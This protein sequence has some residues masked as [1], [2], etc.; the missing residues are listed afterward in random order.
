ELVRARLYQA[1]IYDVCGLSAYRS[2]YSICEW[3]RTDELTRR[4]M[5]DGI[6]ETSTE[7]EYC[8]AWVCRAGTGNLAWC[9]Q[10]STIG[11]DRG[12]VVQ[13]AYRHRKNRGS[14]RRK[15]R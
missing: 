8:F 3:G 7:Y 9:G 12:G 1:G 4:L 14:S 5:W 10:K 2:C 15:R 13:S 11:C 6:A